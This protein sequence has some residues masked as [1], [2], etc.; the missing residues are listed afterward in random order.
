[1]VQRI[2]L[3][4]CYIKGLRSGVGTF[5]S[6]FTL[7]LGLALAFWPNL[8][9]IDHNFIEKESYE[10]IKNQLSPEAIKFVEPFLDK[11]IT[12]ASI[13]YNSIPASLSPT[14]KNL[15]FGVIQNKNDYTSTNQLLLLVILSFILT[16]TVYREFTSGRKYRI[17]HSIYF[18]HHVIHIIRD[19]WQKIFPEHNGKKDLDK[20]NAKQYIQSSLN[21]FEKFFTT[22][23]GA[24]CRACIKVI[25]D[26]STLKVETFVRSSSSSCMPVN[27]DR[28]NDKIEN[29]SDFFEL[30]ANKARFWLVNDVDTEENY[31]NSHLEINSKKKK[32]QQLGYKTSFTWPIRKIHQHADTESNE[33]EIFGFLCIDSKVSGVFSDKYD[34]DSGALVADFYYFLL[35]AYFNI[36]AMKLEEINVQRQ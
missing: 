14:E 7:F 15:L 33:P 20:V 2:K 35:R 19:N 17:A 32:S 31:Q 24:P 25:V 13:F 23:T 10:C 30:V 27:K 4:V 29:N 12:N 5:L 16:G 34:F 9:K 28:E 18:L 11:E 3:I 21:E 1:M 26:F 36:S 8:L 6:I 22:V